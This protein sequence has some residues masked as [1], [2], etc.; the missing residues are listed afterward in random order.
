MS[1]SLSLSLAPDK[2]AAARSK[3]IS[4]FK[5]L[6]VYRHVPRATIKQVGGSFCS[7]EWLNTNKGARDVPNYRS[8][9]VAREYNDS[10]YSMPY[11]FTPPLEA[12]R[13]MVSRASPNDVAKPQDR[14]G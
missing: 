4:F 7:V 8:R 11:A 13:L 9:V 6:G 5:A 2:V 3:P 10:K 1:V 12:L 14:H